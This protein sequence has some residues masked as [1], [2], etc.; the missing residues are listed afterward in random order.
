LQ[1]NI[2][3]LIT[4]NN[5]TLCMKKYDNSIF[6]DEFQ[7]GSL[8]RLPGFGITASGSGSRRPGFGTGSGFASGSA[9]RRPGFGTRSASR[10]PGF[11]LPASGSGSASRRKK[12]TPDSRRKNL[13]P[14]SGAASRLKKRTPGSGLAI[15]SA[16]DKAAIAEITARSLILMMFFF[17]D[18]L[19][20]FY[21]L[22]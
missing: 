11:G 18:A 10:L 5:E 8:S 6:L 3:V 1:K 21:P 12:R 14:A 20:A 2:I 22:F 9:S 16:R 17:Q 4:Q 13:T 7:Q 19:F 15:G